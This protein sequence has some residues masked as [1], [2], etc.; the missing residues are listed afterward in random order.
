MLTFLNSHLIY[1]Q[2]K[3]LN[4]D[5]KQRQNIKLWMLANPGQ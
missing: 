5:F 2:L 4:D 1:S 3:I